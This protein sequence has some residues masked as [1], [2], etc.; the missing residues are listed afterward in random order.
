MYI[1]QTSKMQEQTLNAF[2][3]HSKIIVFDL[4]TTGLSAMNNEVIQICAMKYRV[5]DNHQLEHMD[6]LNR[7]IRPKER[8][9][10]KIEQ[11]T[12]IT[13]TQLSTEDSL[14]DIFPDILSFFKDTDVI[15]GYNSESFDI[16]F[17]HTMYKKFDKILDFQIHLDVLKM[18]R[19][20]VPKHQ[21]GKY[22]L[23]TMTEY[24]NIK[25]IRYHDA[26]GDVTATSR[27]LEIFKDLYMKQYREAKKKG[28]SK[29]AIETEVKSIRY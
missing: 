25:N 7:Y 1:S 26:F 3:F 2:F 16:G 21:C 12:G 15:C 20:L 8:V 5:L 19:E 18:A 24:F 22:N 23:Q 13:N 28:D 27:L 29:H 9:P 11:L 10:R 4:E 6:T 14:E 17:M